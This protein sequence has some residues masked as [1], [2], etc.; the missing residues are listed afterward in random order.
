M[1]ASDFMLGTNIL[2]SGNNY[3]KVALLFQFM[4]MGMLNATSFHK[5]QDIYCVETITEFWEDRRSEVIQCLQGQD[6]V[7]LGELWL[8]G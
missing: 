5:I 1:L 7:C 4:S 8:S 6:V 3:S 2:L